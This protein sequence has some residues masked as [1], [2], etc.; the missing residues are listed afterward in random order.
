MADLRDCAS[1]ALIACDAVLPHARA[2]CA[3]AGLTVVGESQ[4]TFVGGGYTIALLLAES[5]VTVHTWP[6]LACATLDVYVCN[7]SRDNSEGARTVAQG[8]TALFAAKDVQMR[9]VVRGETVHT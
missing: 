9:E 4:H 6:E 7:F 1:Q 8:I 2:L 3:A 5:H